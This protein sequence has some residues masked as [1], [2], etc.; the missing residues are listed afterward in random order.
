MSATIPCVLED[1]ALSDTR[2]ES[3]DS[4][5]CQK[6]TPCEVLPERGSV[7][8]RS[9][10]ELLNA[11]RREKCDG[12]LLL[13]HGKKKKA[14]EWQGGSPV[15]VK[16]NLIRECFGDFLVSE[17]RV[18]PGE[19]DE[20]VER[21]Q[22]GEGLQGEVLV[23]MEVLAEEDRLEA[24]E[25]HA[26]EKFFEL[27]GWRGGQFEVHR[28]ARLKRGSRLG[29]EVHPSRLILEG[30][31]RRAPLRQVDRYLGR[32]AE[33]RVV[34]RDSADVEPLE[35]GLSMREHEWLE[36]L[37]ENQRLG[38]LLTEPEWVRR[39]VFGLVSI[40]FLA[41][42]RLPRDDEGVAGP[43]EDPAANPGVGTGTLEEALRAELLAWGER[44]NKGDA[45]DALG[46]PESAEDE[47]VRLAHVGL[48]EQFAPE[49]FR[50]ASASLQ[51]LAGDLRQ[52]LDAARCEIATA[53]ARACYGAERARD[54]S[55][56][57]APVEEDEGD[58]ALLAETEF[59][60]GEAKLA[61]RDYPGALLCFGRAMEGY[62]TAGEYRSYYGWCLHLC[63]PENAL[64][65][66]EALEHCREGVAL[67]KD[68]E[69]PYLLLGRLYRASGK[70]G[71]ARK[72]F[73]RALQIRPQCV[74][75]MRE[76]RVMNMRRDKA[77]T[78]RKGVLDRILRR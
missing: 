11:L 7:Q 32:H 40:E 55:S 66:G 63:H 44:A 35:L 69:K 25:D 9:I 30:V 36:S 68:R 64:M 48:S 17:G 1:P 50:D 42:E 62:P 15:A 8:E 43:T 46:L 6:G 71:A 16:S 33:E 10:P 75:A 53:A 57:K 65:R 41:V 73:S 26:R 45:Y 19:L 18:R 56:E 54:G 67:A 61:A 34:L 24:L 12:V 59:Q 60:K 70:T 52:R 74:E 29:L 20:S 51:Q 37:R 22:A 47:E 13:D 23:A 72:M 49:R 39:L 58:R 21:M 14:V 76:L 38:A 31:T 5:R 27:F 77:N 2:A 78:L 28:G 3:L 4:S